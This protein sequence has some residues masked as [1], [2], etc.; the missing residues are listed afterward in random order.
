MVQKIIRIW[1]KN[2]SPSEVSILKAIQ[3][4]V[5]AW[6]ALSNET[7]VNFRE[8][9]ISTANQEAAVANEDDLFKDLQNEIDVLRNLQPEFV[10]EDVKEAL[11]TD[12]DAEVSA[13]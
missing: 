12:V 1:E 7:I 4:L 11:L 5:S 13:V 8:A 3:M 9:K 2:N 6:N 10:P